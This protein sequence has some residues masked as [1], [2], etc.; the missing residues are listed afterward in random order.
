MYVKKE[1]P[2]LCEMTRIAIQL[3]YSSAKE[4]A[5]LAAKADLA[6]F[7]LRKALRGRTMNVRTHAKILAALR[8]EL[9][10]AQQV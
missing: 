10:A 5:A 9:Q 7:T 4:L 8:A 6:L 3:K 2:V 1:K